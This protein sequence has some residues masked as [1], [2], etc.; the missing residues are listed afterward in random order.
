V[1]TVIAIFVNVSHNIFASRNL[2]RGLLRKCIRAPTSF[3]DVTP[4]GRYVS[5]TIIISILVLIL[6][7]VQSRK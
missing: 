1:F 2:H 7:V 3:Y 6:V 4:L 5:F